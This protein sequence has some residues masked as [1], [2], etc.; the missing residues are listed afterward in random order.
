MQHIAKALLDSNL[1]YELICHSVDA[2]T[3]A[4]ASL[5]CR[6]HPIRESCTVTA[7]DEPGDQTARAESARDIAARLIARQLAPDS[8]TESAAAVIKAVQLSLH[9]LSRWLGPDGC[10]ALL[11]RA[12]NDA[13]RQYP[14]VADLKVV[15]HSPPSLTGVEESI[16]DH[17]DFVVAAGL[18][19]TLTHL[20]DVLARV[21]GDDLTMKLVD[22][23]GANDISAGPRKTE[24]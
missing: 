17:G 19:A 4:H 6:L 14:F 9:E 23:M 11:V 10:R 12:L 1:Q 24:L 7:K 13:I 8:S 16:A 5:C 18:K 21:I 2:P 15:Q 20:Y 22:Q 3:E